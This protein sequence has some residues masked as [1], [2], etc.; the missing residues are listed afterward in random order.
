MTIGG[1]RAVQVDRNAGGA[2]TAAA[3]GR[4]GLF[5][6]HPQARLFD[7]DGQWQSGDAQ[8]SG[9]IPEPPAAAALAAALAAAAAGLPFR[10][11]GPGDAP[12]PTL[13][14]S[15]ET[16][17]S[18]STGAPRRI[19][20][21]QRSWIES[22]Q[23]NARLFGLGPGSRCAVL[24]QMVQ[25]LS[26]Y[27]ALEALHLGSE[28]HVLSGLRPDRQLAALA[29]RGITTLYASPAQLRLLLDA[30]SSPIDALCNLLTGGAK[31]DPGTRKGLAGLFPN[32]DIREFYGAAE[33]SFITL[34]DAETPEGSVGRAYPGVE[35]GIAD[36]NGSPVETGLIWVRSPLLFEGY[37]GDPGHAIWRDGWLSVGEVGRTEGGFLFIAGR[38]DRM[39]TIADQNVFPE[40]IEAFLM[41]LPGVSRAAV[42]TR[43]DRK[44]GNRI[45]AVV[46][47]G[48]T[49]A[50]LSACRKSL[51]PLKSPRKLHRIEIWPLLPSG[52][53]DRAAL[54]RTLA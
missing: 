42:L 36:A 33:T 27:G 47:G 2:P 51:G 37:A 41:T 17:T 1:T 24:G 23:T 13:A 14:P 52:K 18:G 5:H 22:F 46:E 6:W 40:E 48:D 16:L 20:R 15:F 39:L 12:V 4:D 34:T 43:P 10:I 26:L 8:P 31:L 49:D 45:E 7:A 35:I 11:G 19:R 21:T 32:A 9:V 25:S 28:T 54:E 53:I 50:I 3:T 38:A 44:R 30:R 29:S